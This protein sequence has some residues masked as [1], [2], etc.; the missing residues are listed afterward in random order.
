MTYYRQLSILSAYSVLEVLEEYGVSDL[1][2]K[3]P[4]DVYA[5]GKKICGI[6]LEAVSKEKMECLI[7]GIGINVNEEDFE[8]D[9][10]HMPTSMK[11]ELGKEIDLEEFKEKVYRQLSDNIE[12]LKKGRDFHEEIVVYDYLKGRDVFCEIRGQERQVSVVGINEDYSLRV[13]SQGEVL[14]LSSSEVTFHME[15][16]NL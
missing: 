13:I 5:G 15:K 10:L 12:K 16:G 6:L 1:S 7:I 14:D 11:L 9:Y 4:N 3:W 2:I 8:G